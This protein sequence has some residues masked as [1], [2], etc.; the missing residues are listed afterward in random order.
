MLELKT[1]QLKTRKQV[2]IDGHH[3]TVRRLGN[4]E[5]LDVSQYMRR[6]EQLSSIESK[7]ATELTPKQ[8]KEAEEI[9]AKLSLLF[10][11]LFDDGEDQTK[12]RALVASL[13]DQELGILIQQI[14]KD[15]VDAPEKV[16]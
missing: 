3:Y 1:N 7:D 14:F 15:E 6:L 9:S 10:V 13:T 11:N 16:K 4:I 2:L 12:S 5:Q 8:V